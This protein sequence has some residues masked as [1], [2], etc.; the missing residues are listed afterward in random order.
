MEVMQGDNWLLTL[1]KDQAFLKVLDQKHDSSNQHVL[2]W[3]LA[4]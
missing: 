2:F 4:N 1:S 3:T